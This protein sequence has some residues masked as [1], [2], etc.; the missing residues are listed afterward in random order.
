M[1][2]R[3]RYTF[4]QI[5]FL[6]TAYLSINIHGLTK[7]F[8]NKFGLI[9]TESQ[10]KSTLHNYNIRCG[11]KPKDRLISRSRLFSEQQA[12]FIRE[13]YTG[14]SVVKMTAL[15]NDHFSTDR[16]WQQI[17]DFV[18]RRGITSGRTGCFEKRH[19]SW[20]NG[21]KGYGLT[22]ANKAS[23]KKGNVPA[24]HKPLGTERIC[25]RYGYISIKVAEKD[26]NTGSPTR[27]KRKHV[28]IY[29]QENGPVPK[30]MVVTFK[31]S[32]KTNCEPENLMLISR[33]E[34]LNLNRLGYKNIPAELKPN[35]LMLSKLQIKT[36][37]KNKISN[38]TR[39]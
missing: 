36:W 9:K 4:Y 18:N 20:N 19:I 35:V 28:H 34:L 10:I 14:R 12:K 5:E 29:E 39:I 24:N 27:Y 38:A 26:P 25:S 2:K 3:S 33:A 8:N 13:N 31:D 7:A 16:T 22:G 32:V 1:K 21:T 30:S 17:K 23:F 37:A 6:K 11:R 15:F